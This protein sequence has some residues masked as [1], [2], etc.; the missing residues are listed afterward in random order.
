[1]RQT[2]KFREKKAR[3]VILYLLSRGKMTKQKLTYMLYYI[4]F[5]YFEKF[6]ESICGLNFFKTKQGIKIKELDSILKEV[7]QG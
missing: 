5:D 7:G 4:C 6:E 3:A 2:P 1:M